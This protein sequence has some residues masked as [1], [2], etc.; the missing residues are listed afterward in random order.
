M[1]VAQYEQF[2]P[3][4]FKI[5]TFN[6]W[7]VVVCGTKFVEELRKAPDT[8]VSYEEAVNEV[9]RAERSKQVLRPTP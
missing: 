6:R 3:G 8:D 2:R 5:A 1:I 9:S 4:I 7:I